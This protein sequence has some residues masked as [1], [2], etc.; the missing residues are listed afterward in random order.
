MI[1]Y[2]VTNP[3]P[4][5]AGRMPG[6]NTKLTKA[7]YMTRRKG[8]KPVAGK[9]MIRLFNSTHEYRHLKAVGKEGSQC[10]MILVMMR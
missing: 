5:M 1:C 10:R 6:K 2:L 9:A 3:A 4:G 8:L 7:Q